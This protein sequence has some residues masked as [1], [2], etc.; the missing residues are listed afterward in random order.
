MGVQ[1]LWELLAP[2]GRRVS[3]ETLAGRKLAIDAS[4]W[5]VQFMKAMRDERGEMIK[6]AHVLGFFRRICKLLFLRTK[7]V[8]VFD[9]GT[10]ALKRRTVIARKRLREKAHAKIRKTAEKLLL[11]HLKARKLEELVEEM[12]NRTSGNDDPKGKGVIDGDDSVR[13]SSKGARGIPNQETLDAMLAASLA[14]EE[15]GR[16]DG[17]A[18]TSACGGIEAEDASDEEEMIY[19]VG[20]GKV[21]PTVLAALPP[22]VQLDLLVQMREQ[23]MAENRQKYEK[24]K[25]AP[26]KF[27]EL[28][29]QAYLKTVAF[30]REIDE[31]QKSAGG[32]GVG[33]ISSSRIASEPN[34]EFIFST[35]FTGDKQLLT[36]FGVD[37][38]RGIK[39]PTEGNNLPASAASGHV[40]SAAQGNSA[41]AVVGDESGKGFGYGVETYTDEQGRVRVSRHRSLGIRMTRD[42]QWNLDM[43]KEMEKRNISE[44]G[45]LT[46]NAEGPVGRECPGN[47]HH[48]GGTLE[49]GSGLRPA[50]LEKVVEQLTEGSNHCLMETPSGSRSP[51]QISFFEDELN[52]DDGDLFTNLVADTVASDDHLENVHPATGL[53]HPDPVCS[54]SRSMEHHHLLNSQDLNDGVR[55]ES[56]NKQV[57]VKCSSDDEEVDWEDAPP[58]HPP[59]P[60]DDASRA[61]KE[62]EADIQEAIRRSL[63]DYGVKTSKGLKC[64]SDDEEVDWEDAPPQHPPP[65]VDD[66]FRASK[67]EEADIQE[68]IRRS[69]DDYGVK[70]SKGLEVSNSEFQSSQ[71]DDK[72]MGLSLDSSMDVDNSTEASEIET[73]KDARKELTSLNCINGFKRGTSDSSDTV[74]VSSISRAPR[75]DKKP[76]LLDDQSEICQPSEASTGGEM[77]FENRIAVPDGF[78]GAV[79]SPPATS[80]SQETEME[81]EHFLDAKVR[82]GSALMRSVNDASTISSEKSGNV[83]RNALDAYVES[84]LK[85]DSCDAPSLTSESEICCVRLHEHAHSEAANAVCDEKLHDDLVVEE[86]VIQPS[87]GDEMARLRQEQM[88]LGDE[89]RKLERNA[90]SVTNEMFS[91]CQELLQMFGLPYIIAPME[92][93]AQCAYMELIGL[94]DGVVTDDSDA[95]LFGARNVY[96]NIFDDRKYVE[97]YFMKD[98]EAELGL[99][100]E[101]LVRMALLLGSDYTEGVSGIGI[102][103]AIEVVHAFPEEDGLQ[104]FREW[105]DSPDPSIV[106]KVHSDNGKASRKKS[107]KESSSSDDFKANAD[108]FAVDDNVLQSHQNELHESS[109][110]KLKEIFME[111]HRNVSKNWH[112]PPSFPSE[113]VISAYMSPQIDKSS[114]PFSW[115]KPDLSELR[116]LCWEKFGWANQK[117]D[118][119]LLPVLKEYNRHE[120]QLRLE[121]FYTFNER[122]AKIRS[123]RIQKAVKGLT[124]KRS[125]HLMVD[126]GTVEDD[127]AMASEGNGDS[128]AKEIKGFNRQSVKQATGRE[129][130]SKSARAGLVGSEASAE[131]EDKYVVGSSDSVA[132]EWKDSHR[133]ALKQPNISGTKRKSVE[134]GLVGS[135]TCSESEECQ[136]NKMKSPKQR[137]GVRGKMQKKYAG[138]ANV[139]RFQDVKVRQLSNPRRSGRSRKPVVYSVD[140]VDSESPSSQEKYNHLD[141]TNQEPFSDEDF[142]KKDSAEARPDD[143][144]PREYLFTGGGFC[145]DE[146]DSN[147]SD[148]NEISHEKL[149]DGGPSIISSVDTEQI[150][151]ENLQKQQELGGDPAACKPGSNETTELHTLQ[152]DVNLRALPSLRRRRKPA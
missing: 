141:D 10:P 76:C 7:P 37:N 148:L 51:L 86:T 81:K 27:S 47:V 75:I 152:S 91:E 14:A 104:N 25:K 117:A 17:I 56:C 84:G 132:N 71:A 94:V 129:T 50:N 26:E 92:A 16:F 46:V 74:L 8:F 22:S 131:R 78:I 133:Q 87:L 65:P 110:P 31:V 33:G 30:R 149:L 116:K 83:V 119:L 18:S 89:Q 28:Q 124:G 21:D 1:G 103:N 90:E 2:V 128:G 114:E 101:K 3:V 38:D 55:M 107:S 36:S 72:K 122:F 12:K 126:S 73:S 151:V 109:I 66:A 113:P 11:S 40:S 20:Q 99:T 45:K 147:V 48:S 118:E 5:M 24:A 49:E 77:T 138:N 120:T 69:L 34:R 135:E 6:N 79:L 54:A 57:A 58:Q 143:N 139:D 29:I 32:K 82:E 112:M 60:V 88:S 4:I 93:E 123:Q 67:E 15:D 150:E 144:S 63:D 19:P 70:T 43:M 140:D 142:G 127:R 97:T 134:A 9:G 105:F 62:E 145:L 96:K 53:T 146:D 125:S 108:T 115:G 111:K 98:I 95:F 68:A 41:R 64:S 137:R 52:D 23:L 130:K 42:L 61:S 85:K 106:E 39:N 80:E 35:S 121:A 44:A 136:S 13:E 59:P 100:R 102:V